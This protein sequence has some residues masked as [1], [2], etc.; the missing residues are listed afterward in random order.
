[1][2]ILLIP[3][4]LLHLSDGTE[5][6]QDNSTK[7]WDYG[8][9]TGL[10]NW[11]KLYPSCD[12][13]QQ[14]PI[15]LLTNQIVHVPRYQRFSFIWYK[16]LIKQAFME[17]NGKTVQLFI[18][19]PMQKFK[20][21]GLTGT[22]KF[23]KIIFHWGENSSIGSEHVKN[24][25]RYPL[26]MQLIHYNT[27]YE[28][29]EA[30]NKPDGLAI[31][32]VL[33]QISPHINQALNPIID[34]LNEIK[35]ENSLAIIRQTFHLNDLL[36]EDK[37]YYRYKGSLTS[38][39]CHESV[40][41]TIFKNK[42]KISESQL[43]QFRLLK[44]KSG[45]NLV[46]NFRPVQPTNE[47][48]VTFYKEIHQFDDDD[49]PF[50]IKDFDDDD[51]D[52]DIDIDIKFKNDKHKNKYK[53]KNKNKDKSKDKYKTKDKNKYKYKY[54]NSGNNLIPTTLI[55]LLASMLAY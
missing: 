46:N 25:H 28:P 44:T 1:M 50:V 2:Y 8:E 27:R 9:N 7:F 42:L 49:D 54:K 55:I 5:G 51:D 20:H 10:S 16:L 40:V 31:L 6:N 36:P 33:F 11:N 19:D 48:I 26:E 12:G 38:P 17:N 13:F 45:Y 43:M 15:N 41:W 14:S 29:E 35:E 52:I 37:S 3:L 22:Y 4:F 34:T 39:P 47:R 21:G 53:D 18:E 30:L 23:L 32:V 24:N